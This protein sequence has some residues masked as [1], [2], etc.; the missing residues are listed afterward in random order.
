MKKKKINKKLEQRI[1]AL[2]KIITSSKIT[3]TDPLNKDKFV[4]I[5]IANGTYESYIQTV[6]QDKNSLTK[7]PL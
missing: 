3:L 2:E 6:T 4:I 1:E 5:E 7:A